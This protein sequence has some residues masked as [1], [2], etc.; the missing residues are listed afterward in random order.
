MPEVSEPYI[1][2][3][4]EKRR[5]ELQAIISRPSAE[6][7]APFVELLQEVDSA[8]NIFT[9]ARMGPAWCAREPSSRS[10]CMA[11]PLVRVCL[12]C[13]STEERRALEGDLELASVVQRGLLP[14]TDVRNLATGAFTTSTSR[15]AWSA[16]IIAT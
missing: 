15:R 9:T 7:T 11:D 1:R 10:G 8:S 14:Q 16:A 12:D 6:P 3:Q 5:E 13:L 4:L 2:E